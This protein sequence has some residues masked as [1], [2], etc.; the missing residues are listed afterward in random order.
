[1]YCVP[2]RQFT[3]KSRERGGI[4]PFTTD[5]SALLMHLA[6][7]SISLFEL[8]LTRLKVSLAQDTDAARGIASTGSGVYKLGDSED[9]NALFCQ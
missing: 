4:L 9:R 8:F 5:P 6:M 2:V 3:S 1:M 7:R